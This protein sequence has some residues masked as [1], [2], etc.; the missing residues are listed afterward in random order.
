M[1]L[2]YAAQCG[3]TNTTRLLLDAGVDTSATDNVRDA[4]SYLVYLL[5]V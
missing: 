1:A 3:Y 4:F 5:S 2:F